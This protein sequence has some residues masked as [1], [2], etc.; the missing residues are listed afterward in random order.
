MKTVRVIWISWQAGPIQ[1]KCA[2]VQ[3]N[4]KSCICEPGTQAL[5]PEDDRLH[6][7]LHQT[8]M[9]QRMQRSEQISNSA[10]D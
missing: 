1:I 5:L 9:L 3:Q 6:L 8:L 2:A 10:R 4:M 7:G